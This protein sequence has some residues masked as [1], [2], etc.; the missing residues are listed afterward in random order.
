MLDETRFVYRFYCSQCLRF[1]PRNLPTP[2]SKGCLPLPATQHAHIT[3]ATTAVAT[4]ADTRSKS[5]LRA[6][7]KVGKSKQPLEAFSPP[8]LRFC[9]AFQSDQVDSGGTRA[10]SL[11]DLSCSKLR[12]PGLTAEDECL[13]GGGER[14]WFV[15]RVGCSARD[16]LFVHMSF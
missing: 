6:S 9:R 4:H 8:G 13:A 3:T 15:D 12:A 2:Q 14:R 16:D 11:P 10:G 5:H 7:R 1:T